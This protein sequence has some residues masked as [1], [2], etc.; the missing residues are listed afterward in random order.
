MPIYLRGPLCATYIRSGYNYHLS[1][2]QCTFSRGGPP[3]GSCAPGGQ[4][5]RP[6]THTPTTSTRTQD[7]LGHPKAEQTHHL[8]QPSTLREYRLHKPF[9]APKHQSPRPSRLII[10]RSTSSDTPDCTPQSVWSLHGPRPRDS[11]YLRRVAPFDSRVSAVSV[12]SS[13]GLM[14]PPNIATFS[15]RS[16]GILGCK[17]HTGPR[18][19]NSTYTERR[20]NCL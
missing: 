11:L 19:P 20:V 2:P 9:N 16:Q 8:S 15:Q 14:R 10:R 12:G 18:S 4:S 13:S 1:L 7:R 6:E 5:P 3:S 17:S